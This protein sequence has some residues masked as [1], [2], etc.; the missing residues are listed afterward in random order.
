MFFVTV[1]QNVLCINKE[2]WISYGE[3]YASHVSSVGD[4]IIQAAVTTG[5]D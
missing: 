2:L 5:E 3:I 1:E 4:V